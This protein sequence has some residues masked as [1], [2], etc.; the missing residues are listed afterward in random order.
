MRP[1]DVSAIVARH[2]GKRGGL[3]AI[4][5]EIQARYG[6]LPAEAVKAI[7]EKTGR[8]LVDVYGVATFYRS[9]SL[10]PRGKHLCSICLG[11]ACHVRGG[12]VI[13]DEFGRQ[14]GVK[15]G[16]T[17]ADREFT[18]ET[19][20]CLGACALGPIVVVDGHYFA[21]VSPVKVKEILERARAGLDK[22]EIKTDR[23]IFPVEVSCPRCNHSLM[24]PDHL[25]DG[26]PAITVN[27]SFGREHGWLRLSCLYGSY[28]VES[29]HE[30]PKDVLVDFFCPHCHTHLIGASSCPECGA[31]MVPMIV[32]GGGI[33]QACSRRGCKGHILDLTGPHFPGGQADLLEPVLAI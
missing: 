7:A 21:E 28:T 32:R 25:V 3:I 18:L 9:F 12:P 14:L 5:Q 6:Y 13:A 19:V 4:L 1:E 2:S 22:V 24:D 17:T 20:N 8:S 16:E 30:L 27:Q 15:P 33:V 29:E 31:P 26:Y 23:R 10:T 11:T